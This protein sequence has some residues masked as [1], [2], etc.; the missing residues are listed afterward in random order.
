[1]QVRSFALAMALAVVPPAIAAAAPGQVTGSVNLRAGPSTGYPIITTIPAG[2]RIDV[3]NCAS[4]CSVGFAGYSG[5]VSA[6]YV[7]A[8]A[9]RPAVP[10]Y[11]GSIYYQGVTARRRRATAIIKGRGG[12]RRLAAWAHSGASGRSRFR[13]RSLGPGEM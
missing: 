9:Y 2:A 12:T 13:G 6:S 1:M 4:W 10:R 7:A 3:R 5:W 8:G 11:T